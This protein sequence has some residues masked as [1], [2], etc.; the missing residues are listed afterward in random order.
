VPTRGEHGSYA[1]DKPPV[2]TLVDRGSNNRFV[3]PAKSAEKST[4]RL[5]LDNQEQELLTVYTDGFRAYDPLDDDDTF[6]RKYV[7]HSALPSEV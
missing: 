7:V 5:L 4:I 3:I 6:N 2:F 1:G